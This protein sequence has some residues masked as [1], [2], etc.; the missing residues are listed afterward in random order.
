MPTEKREQKIREVI[1]KRQ[2]DLV[3]VLEDTHD[4][5]NAE[6]V[7]RSCDAF[8][9]QNVYLIH[10]NLAPYEPKSIGRQSSSSANKWLDFHS[11]LSTKDCLTHLKSEGYSIYATTLSDQSVDIRQVDFTSGKIAIVF[12]NERDGLSDMA[13]QLADYQV[14]IPMH[15]MVQSFNLSVSA[16][17]CLFEISKQRDL[18]KKD[19]SLSNDIQNALFDNFISR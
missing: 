13:I 15:G 11:Y 18:S 16:S 14:I 12:G 17:L 8:G 5:H 6:A 10:E 19:F 9:V 4:P 2:S 7:F 3:V 1:S